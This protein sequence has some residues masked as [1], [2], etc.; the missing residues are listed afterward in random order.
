MFSSLA[1]KVALKKVGLSSDS[2]NLPWS[3]SSSSSSSSKKSTRNS[4]PGAIPGFD[5]ETSS[6]WKPAWMTVKSL[7]LTVQPWLTPVPPP[8]PVAEAPTVGSMAPLDRDRELTFGGGKKVLVVFLRCVGCACTFAAPQVLSNCL[9]PLTNNVFPVVAQKTFLQLRTIATRFPSDLTCIAVSHSSAAATQKWLDL[10]GGP[11]NV[12]IVIDEDRAV[13]AAW[14]LGLGSVWYVLNPTSTV[15]GFKE[16]GWLGA[17]VAGSLQRSGMWKAGG[18]GASLTAA[19]NVARSR[20]MSTGNGAGVVGSDAPEDGPA[21][22]MGNKWQESGAWA[23]DGKG[24]IVWGG[25]AARADDVTDLEAGVMA[26]G[27]A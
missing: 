12:S 9:A 24:K 10:L 8:I 13:Y 5:D 2:F 19:P 21:T 23:V 26:L 7:P 4:S 22:V 1:T 11:W 15:A 20:N 17:S 6:T 27:L 16:K 3:D 14:G 18:A 25:K